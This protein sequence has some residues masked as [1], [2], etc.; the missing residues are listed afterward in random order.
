MPASKAVAMV[1]MPSAVLMS[2]GVTPQMAYAKPL[3]KNPF[4]DGPCVSQ[5]DRAEE[6]AEKE[7]E[8]AAKAEEER[9]RAEAERKAAEKAE[10]EKEDAEQ[11]D[12]SDSGSDSGSGSGSGDDATG[13]SSGSGGSGGSSEPEPSPS[14]EDGSGGLLGGVGD[15]LGD[16]LGGGD[17][18]EKAE[19]EPT[20]SET[21][22]ASQK[23]EKKESSDP[24]GD[25]VGEV[26]EGVEDTVG[27]VEEGLGDVTDGLSGSSGDDASSDETGDDGA[28]DETELPVGEDGKKVFP[29]VEEE[30]VAGE[31]EQTPAM[32]PNQ[33]WTLKASSLTIRGQ[34]YE[35]VFN[36][37][38]ADGSTKQVLKFTADSVDIGD[39]HQIVQGQDGLQ[40]H[41]KAAPGST[42]TIR[43]GQVTLYTE[44]LEGKLFGLIPI[45]FDP[46]HPPPLNLPDVFFTDVTVQQAG[47][48][49]GTLTV[50]GLH[51]T[52]SG[53]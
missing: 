35:G 41:V 28:T 34:D 52:I 37:R 38:T 4:S 51:S 36:V 6:E 26:G 19:P 31:A 53:G 22:D 13:G 2:M 20:P 23:P 17:R 8:A 39:L 32:L 1:A 3:P 7:A 45:T 15:A 46:E 49:G 18:E 27:K 5:Q 21:P 29:C 48:F 16:L 43:E 50:P 24:V 47:Q 40:Y 44:R 11:D 10:Q 42:S 12:A 14:E 33:P 30:K 25:A 9:K